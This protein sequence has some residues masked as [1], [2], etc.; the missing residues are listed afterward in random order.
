MQ[1][2]YMQANNHFLCNDL[3]HVI[4]AT[5]KNRLALE[6][7]VHICSGI[8]HIGCWQHDPS[9]ELFCKILA[10]KKDPSSMN[11]TQYWKIQMYMYIYVKHIYVY[12]QTPKHSIHATFTYIYHWKIPNKRM[13][14]KFICI[15]IYILEMSLKVSLCIDCRLV[16]HFFNIDSMTSLWAHRSDHPK[17]SN[18]SIFV[19]GKKTWCFFLVLCFLNISPKNV[20]HET[21]KIPP[22]SWKKL[23]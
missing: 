1:I 22:K 20:S 19:P 11:R 6:F 7:Q 5:I 12:I 9:L 15:Y 10:P 3:N 14:G 8:F 2:R 23:I 18:N 4:E 16:S 21:S 13:C 17:T